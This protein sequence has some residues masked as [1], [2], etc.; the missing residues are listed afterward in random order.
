M[1]GFK[2]F[3]RDQYRESIGLKNQIINFVGENQ[4]KLSGILVFSVGMVVSVIDQNY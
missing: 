3:E 4:Q 1:K 2:H